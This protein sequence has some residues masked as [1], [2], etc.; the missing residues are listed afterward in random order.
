MMVINLTDQV[1]ELHRTGK[2]RLI[3]VFSRNRVPGLPDVQPTAEVY[4]DMIAALF[5]GL[6]APAATPKSIIERIASANHQVVTSND[7]RGRLTASGFDVM[8]D[9][10]EEAQRFVE[11]EYARIVPLVNT[12]GF[13]LP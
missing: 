5:I 8:V 2:I 13:K 12:L 7:F 4:P 9:S 11:A 10:P 3:T 1:V 6:F